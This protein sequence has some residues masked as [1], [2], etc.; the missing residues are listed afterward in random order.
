MAK[1]DIP[2]PPGTGLVG[3]LTPDQKEFLKQMWA[4]MFR[5]LDG[6]EASAPADLLA[7]PSASANA[8]TASVKSKTS[9]TKKGWFGSKKEAAPAAADE[10]ASG[11]I[12]LSEYSLTTEQLRAAL[13][14]NILGDHPGKQLRCVISLFFHRELLE[15]RCEQRLTLWSV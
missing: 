14:N 4:E 6:N 12:A 2:T 8:E 13:W 3:T 5:L 15:C 7:V 1:T 11:V 10:S 9:T